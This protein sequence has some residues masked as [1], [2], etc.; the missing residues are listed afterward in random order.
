MS[1]ALADGNGKDREENEDREYKVEDKIGNKHQNRNYQDHR[2]QSYA[3][4]T[5]F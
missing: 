5:E 2:E 4:Q 3:R 1:L